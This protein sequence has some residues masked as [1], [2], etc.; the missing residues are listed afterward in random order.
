MEA[1]LLLV[2]KKHEKKAGID[3]EKSGKKRRDD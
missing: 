2:L 3:A 1:G